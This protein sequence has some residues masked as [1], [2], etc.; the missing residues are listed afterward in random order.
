MVKF[1]LQAAQRLRRFRRPRSGR[2]NY[3]R[4]TKSEQ[5][6]KHA[7][8]DQGSEHLWYAQSREQAHQ[9]LEQERQQYGDHDRHH[10]WL[11]EIQSHD[12]SQQKKP[13]DRDRQQ[14]SSSFQETSE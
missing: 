3:A 1:F 6:E 8:H 7:H 12:D 2:L 5:T 11:A 13:E 14:R 4:D 10:K 9:R